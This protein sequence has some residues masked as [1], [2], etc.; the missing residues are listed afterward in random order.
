MEEERFQLFPLRSVRNSTRL[1]IYHSLKCFPASLTKIP[2]DQ[3]PWESNSL[4]DNSLFV[5]PQGAR[6]AG[7]WSSK[8]D[9][10]LR[11]RS[12]AGTVLLAQLPTR[13]Q[14]QQV[15]PDAEKLPKS[16]FNHH[17]SQQHGQREKR[18][19]NSYYHRTEQTGAEV[20]RQLP[21]LLEAAQAPGI[22]PQQ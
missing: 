21:H 9:P 8:A 13:P 12:T 19:P 14:G 6:R 11:L 7:I 15:L 20:P 16:D 4:N 17:L 10:A 18:N 3:L 1:S 2:E 5:L 22:Q